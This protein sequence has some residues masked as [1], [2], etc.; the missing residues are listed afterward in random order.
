[1]SGYTVLR[2]T[3]QFTIPLLHRHATRLGDGALGA[4]Q[5][6]IS[7]VVEPGVYRVTWDGRQLS[8]LKLPGS[9]LVE[10]MAT[11]VMASPFA[12][13]S[14]RFPKQ[15][16][17]SPYDAVRA[18][19]VSTLLTD[20][21]G[22]EVFEACSAAVV[23][24]NGSA[25]VLPPEDRPAVASLAEAAI[26][27][28]EAVLR[29]PIRLTESWPLLLVNAVTTCVPKGSAFPVA[30]RERLAALLVKEDA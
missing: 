17:P 26:A 8:T 5:H 22:G 1:M 30:I 6:F 11:R 19:G 28:H 2:V 25:L 14:G 27:A 24:W 3:E 29:A 7:F 21:S 16:S 18:E 23:A 13:Q 12:E 15:S 9:R 20:A 4:L 10:G